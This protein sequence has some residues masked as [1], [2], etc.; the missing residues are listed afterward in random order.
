VTPPPA[1]MALVAV[2]HSR[3]ANLERTCNQNLVDDRDATTRGRH[4]LAPTDQLRTGTG[5]EDR[6]TCFKRGYD[7]A[8]TGWKPRRG[9]DLVRARLS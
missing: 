9:R 1:S 6:I 8:H 4:D 5:S 3:A 2:S 7:W